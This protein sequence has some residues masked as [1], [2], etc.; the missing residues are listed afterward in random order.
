MN[1]SPEQ[2][3]AN[4]A[5]NKAASEAKKLQLKIDAKKN[6]KPVHSIKINIEWSKSG[7]PTCSAWVVYHDKTGEVFTARAGGWGYC[8][9]STVL[10]EIFNSCLS[11]K[12]Y[13][14]HDQIIQLGEKKPYGISLGQNYPYFAGGVGTSCYYTITKFLGD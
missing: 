14:L 2:K 10:A 8:K 1:L 12:L 7:H 6:Q 5:A 13:E 3:A 11:Y 9:E 4:K